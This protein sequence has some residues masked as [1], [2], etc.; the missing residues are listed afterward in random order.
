MINDTGHTA[1]RYARYESLR[2]TPLQRAR[3]AALVTI[4]ALVPP[5]GN[6]NTTKYTTPYQSLGAR[7][8]NNLAAKLLLALLPPNSP[9]FRL[10]IDD[11]ELELLT[12][13]QGMRGQ[14]EQVFDKMERSVMTEIENT[15]IRTKAF[16]AL[17][18]LI[19]AG[20]VLC[21]ILPQGGMRVFPLS[22][23]V[24]KRDPVG[25]LLEVIVKETVATLALPESVRK[26]HGLVTAERPVEDTVDVYTCIHRESPDRFG[27][28]QELNGKT[29]AGSEGFYPIEAMP[30]MALRWTAVENE[31]YGRGFIE[32]YM[33]DLK[34]LE[35]LS[36]AILEGAAA[37]S[38]VL[39]L[40]RPNAT[41]NKRKVVEAPN[42]AIVEGNI[43]DIG[44]L[45]LA[46]YGDFRVA[47]EQLEKLSQ[48]LA[49][50]FLLNTAVQRNGE[51]VT[52]EEIRFMAGE[53]EGS[54]GGVYSVLSQEF[55]QPLVKAILATKQQ[56]GLLPQLPQGLV[57]PMITTGMEALGRGQDLNKLNLLLQ[58]I[59]PLGP[60]VIA[61][62][63]NVGD[64]IARVGVSLG[65]DMAGLIK[66]EE[67]VQAEQAQMQ[68]DQMAQQII[69]EYA[70]A[71]A[72]RS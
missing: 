52:A 8:L 22:R 36:K 11:Y 48:S 61:S 43:E 57:K 64:Y 31:D 23:Y 54:L 39:F 29:V 72:Q 27:I 45:Q 68:Q 10:S 44:V 5:D 30:W 69:P 38:K 9:F 51:R 17:K 24:V 16:E 6:S 19:V 42:G 35:G 37:A 49:L 13:Q 50:A 1:Q 59:A 34:S 32:E 66:T 40:L 21:Q 63:L 41:T 60:E 70:K 18:Q 4:P 62:R 12:Q 33:G 46:K 26:A 25:N 20:N 7:G 3:D 56:Q 2:S 28:Y 53:L 14:I 55:Q 67:E 71:D 65:I 15:G 47:L 58:Q